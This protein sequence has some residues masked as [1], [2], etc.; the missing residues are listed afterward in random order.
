[1]KNNETFRFVVP[2][3]LEKSKEGKWKIRGLAS[4]EVKDR[5]GE[6]IIQKG[7]NLNHIDDKKGFLNW[8]HDNKPESTIG[9]LTGYS[10]EGNKTYIEGELFQKHEKAKAVYSILESL[11]EHGSKAMGLS[12]EGTVVSRNPNN[13][14]II[15]KCIVKNVALTLNPVYQDSYAELVKSFNAAE[16]LEFD[17]TQETEVKAPAPVGTPVFTANEVVDMVQKALS[18]GNGY[19]DAPAN[20]SGG[21]ALA[22]ESMDSDEKKKKKARKPLKKLDKSLYKSGMLEILDKLQKL[23]PEAS[24]AQIWEVMKERISDNFS[25]LSSE[26]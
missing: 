1:M 3:T 17:A 9:I 25:E 14:K 8:D 23:Y 4:A 2:A 12:V 16:S 20:L 10:R 11:Q 7:I 18:S 22:T 13:P 26:K 5:Q 15:E 24:R 21:A 19:M 6:I